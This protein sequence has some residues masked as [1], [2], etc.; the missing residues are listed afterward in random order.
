MSPSI[1]FLAIAVLLPAAGA[2]VEGPS[3]D[4]VAEVTSDLGIP[5]LH[6]SLVK[7]EVI[8]FKTIKARAIRTTVIARVPAVEIVFIAAE[9]GWLP[10]L[11]NKDLAPSWEAIVPALGIDGS[12]AEPRAIAQDLARL[13]VDPEPRYGVVL[14]SS[15]SIPTDYPSSDVRRDLLRAGKSEEEVRALL[16]RDVTAEIRSPVV[17]QV[18]AKAVLTFTTW[19]YFGGEVVR[20]HVDLEPTLKVRREPLA[21]KVG[22]Y[23]FYY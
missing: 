2:C 12:L 10:V 5:E 1:L 13:L 9:R 8:P 23:D 4:E 16:L 3:L 19:H 17:E 18:G 22:S 14:D 11:I 21:A 15:A 7:Q 6:P 20:W